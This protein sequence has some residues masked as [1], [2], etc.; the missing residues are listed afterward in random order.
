MSSENTVG[1]APENINL[2]LNIIHVTEDIVGDGLKGPCCTAASESEAGYQKSCGS[3]Q[4][5]T[6]KD[7]NLLENGENAFGKETVTQPL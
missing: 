2:N 4:E 6:Y 3:T 7:Y 1:C 5:P